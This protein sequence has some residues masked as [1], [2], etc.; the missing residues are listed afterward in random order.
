MKN[1]QI[2]L[3]SRPQG[4]VSESTFKL[5]ESDIPQAGEGEFVVRNHYLSLDPY[6]RGRMDEAKSYAQS[7]AVGD[8]M[9]GTT[10]GEVI[11]S[12]HAKFNAGDF[13]E[14]RTGW[15]LYGKSN[16]GGTR[17]VDRNTGAAGDIVDRTGRVELVLADRGDPIQGRIGIVVAALHA[18]Q[19]QHPQG[20][21][22]GEFGTH[23]HIHHAIHG[24]GNDRDLP[25]D[26]AQAPAAVGDR[27]VDGATSGH[28]RNLIDAIGATHRA[29][30]SELNVHQKLPYSGQPINRA[31]G[32]RR[33][34]RGRPGCG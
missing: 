6:M 34:G 28:Q 16:G 26:A 15:Q 8:V 21:K 11:E 33:P 14:T 1:K 24:A 27:R 7:A 9:V 22:P 23:A 19:I 29:G 2:L 30:A 17:R 3:A 32:P 4:A 31:E 18:L 13:V 12:K 5:V 10:V 20:A 25:G